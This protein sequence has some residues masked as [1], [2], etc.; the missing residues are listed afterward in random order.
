MFHQCYPLVHYFLNDVVLQHRKRKIHQLN[1][2]RN[3]EVFTTVWNASASSLL[4]LSKEDLFKV[5][6][7]KKWYLFAVWK[8]L[9]ISWRC[10]LTLHSEAR[11][12]ENRCQEKMNV[13]IKNLKVNE[14]KWTDLSSLI[15]FSF[16]C[17]TLQWLRILE[18][19]QNLNKGFLIKDIFPTSL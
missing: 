14:C 4:K 19:L 9:P 10:Y 13:V 1:P 3:Q 17:F 16:G 5:H 2:S 18:M 7:E 11:W 15:H 12:L 8:V 6:Y